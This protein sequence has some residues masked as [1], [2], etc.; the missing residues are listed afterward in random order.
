[1]QN[2]KILFATMPFDGHFNPLTGLAVYLQSMGYEVAWYAGPSYTEKLRKLRIAHYPYQKALEISHLNLEELFP[3]RKRIKG[4]IARIRFDLNHVFINRIPEFVEDVK[5]IHQEW[6]FDMIVYD[7]AF[8]AGPVLK[9]LLNIPVAAVGVVPYSETSNDLPPAGMGLSPSFNFLGKKWHTFLTYVTTKV[10]LK[11]CTDLFNQFMIQYSLE[12]TKDFVFDAAVRLPDLYL[13]SGV[14]GFEYKRKNRSKN[15][16]FVGPLLPYKGNVKHYF[17]QAARTK[18]YQ[19]VLLVT[20]GTLERDINKIIVPTLEAYKN[21]LDTLVIVTTGGFQTA[22]LRARYPQTNFIIE[23]F[24]DFNS[25]MPF[26]HVYVTNAGYGG[27][28]LSIQH[29]VPMVTAGI[30]EGKNEIA[31]RVGY[32]KVGIDLKTE[33][34]K[35]AQIRRSV[36]EILSNKQYR[37]NVQKLSS[38]FRQYASN[39]LSEKYIRELLQKAEN[40]A[41]LHQFQEVNYQSV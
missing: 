15:V 5:R 7:F 1:M 16:R 6:P 38:E 28:M 14:P 12:P 25:V 41:T 10:L 8:T 23:D 9:Q 18:E 36:E 40:S 29:N 4:A 34:P 22:E 35:P 27:V 26:V 2:K 32:F 24:I 39:E 33:T 13:Q 11:P 30:H 31:A 3:E 21:N 19:K 17:T 20:Q 37:R